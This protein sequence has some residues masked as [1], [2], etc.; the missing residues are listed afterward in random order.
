M[1]TIHHIIAVGLIAACL[2]ANAQ[3]SAARVAAA[4]AAVRTSEGETYDKALGPYIGKAIGACIPAGTS[5]PENL[6]SFT[7]IADVSSEG[8]VRN[9]TVSPHSTVATCF[10]AKFVQ[11]T[12]PPPPGSHSAA[13]FSPYPIVVEMKVAP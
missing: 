11:S 4:K 2:Q 7:L 12:L 6:G 5:N 1:P 3:D 13:A 10:Q 8:Q 9:A